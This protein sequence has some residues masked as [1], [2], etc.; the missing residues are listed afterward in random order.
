LLAVDFDF[1]AIVM[2]ICDLRRRVVVVVS[3]TAYYT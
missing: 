2:T 3:V 1:P